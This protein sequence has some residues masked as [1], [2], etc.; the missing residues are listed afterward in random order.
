MR[1]T[2]VRLK[3]IF[4]I[5]YS[6]ADLDFLF[7][8]EL[9]RN[10][11]F[12]NVRQGAEFISFTVGKAVLFARL[13]P[14]SDAYVLRQ[15]FIEEEYKP[16]VDFFG[17]NAAGEV[18]R[19]IDAGANIGYTSAYFLR[20]FPTAKIACIEPDPGNMELLKKNLGR[21][22]DSG[23]ALPF[24]NA[25]MADENKDLAIDRT[26]GEGKDWAISVTESTAETGLKS[27]TVAQIMRELGWQEVDVLKIDIEGAERFVFGEN[28]DLS[29]L[30]SVKLL[31]IEIH[32]E[33]GVREDMYRQLRENRFLIFNFGE[34]TVGLNKRYADL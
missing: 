30:R 32:D 20:H 28:A 21:Y 16:V 4:R 19:I 24:Q 29:Y 12:S 15:I 8:S 17:A 6:N 26:R 27:I 1:K 22:I 18:L 5:S 9:N 2:I 34:T 11:L 31:A 33:F 23:A 13:H 10:K 7:L 25:L 14:H 3:R